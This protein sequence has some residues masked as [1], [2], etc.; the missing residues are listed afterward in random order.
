MKKNINNKIKLLAFILGILV[1]ATSCEYQEIT[2]A[3]YPNQLLYMPTAVHGIYTIDKLP[4]NPE[5][6]PTPGYATRFVV[7]EANGKFI[8]PLGVYRSGYERKADINVDLTV[9]NDTVN[10]LIQEAVISTSTI[11]LPS[12]KYTIPSSVVV[13]DGS[14]LAKFNLE[15][16]LNYLLS[17]PDEVVAIAIHISSSDA[18]VNEDYQ[19]T[20]VVIHTEILNL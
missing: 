9:Q 18:E 20:V 14:E 19:T 5:Y 1:I 10:N 12:D 16:D 15:I 11:I 8:V 6:V 13:E 3:D 7:D 17:I 2:D 4:E